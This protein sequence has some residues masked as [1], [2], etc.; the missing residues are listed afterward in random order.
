MASC[1]GAAGALLL[2]RP[3]TEYQNYWQA[4]IYTCS[5]LIP[6]GMRA[7]QG[8]PCLTGRAPAKRAPKRCSRR[9][10]ECKLR[11]YSIAHADTGGQSWNANDWD[12]GQGA[13]TSSS[14]YPDISLLTAA[15]RVRAERKCMASAHM[16][17]I[18]ISFIV[19]L[20]V[21]KG[22]IS[23]AHSLFCHSNVRGAN[24]LTCL[25]CRTA[26]YHYGR[27]QISCGCYRV[28]DST[29]FRATG[30]SRSTA[31]ARSCSSWCSN[32]QGDIHEH[33]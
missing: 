18:D 7:R 27:A 6:E 4:G 9:H 11:S 24:T 12:D 32:R 21:T 20:S 17:E 10:P 15:E 16:P 22:A 2:P 25:G 5:M 19:L 30:V 13:S 26:S 23:Q 1:F 33:L 29:L 28:K 8:R 14:T 31:L 3:P